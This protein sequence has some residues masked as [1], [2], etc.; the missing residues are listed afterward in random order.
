M[1]SNSGIDY[2]LITEA[3]NL[4]ATHEQLARLYQRYCFARQFAK[5]KNTLEAACGSG[6][7]LGY[8]AKE[9]KSVVGVDIDEKNVGL[10]KNYYK[11]DEKQDTDKKSKIKVELMDI[12]DL[13]FP[14]KCFDVIL[15]Y[16]ALYY[17][18][19]PVKFILEAERILRENGKLIICTVNKD[20]ADF[21]P[22]LYTYKYFSV[23]ELYEILKEKFLK[24]EMYGGFPVNN[25]GIKNKI[26]SLI[27]RVAVD[28]NLIPSSLKA[29]AYLKRI[30]MGRLV[31]L[32]AAVYE[33]MT[34]YEAPIP[35]PSNTINSDF[36]IIY[37]VASK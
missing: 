14:E 17:L 30:F 11:E 10:A 32:P 18:Q 1:A 13:K 22:S 29:R 33:D 20:W 6:I 3:P 2:S 8:L 19:N 5:D 26:V 16:E 9:A 24:I 23:P 4:K 27:K 35:I 12:H 36:K 15:L 37:A 28:F 25:H 31:P 21:H 7:G 34:P